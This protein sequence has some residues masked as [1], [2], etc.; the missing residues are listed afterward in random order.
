ME[1]LRILLIGSTGF[2]GANLARHLLRGQHELHVQVRAT[3]NLW[4]IHDI[5]DQVELHYFDI[6]SP[7]STENALRAANPE[8]VILCSKYGGGRADESQNRHYAVNFQGLRNILMPGQRSGVEWMINT[9]SAYEYGDSK[10][11]VSERTLPRPVGDYGL[12]KLFGTEYCSFFSR[13]LGLPVVTLRPFQAYGH[14]EDASRLFPYLLQ[15]M[16]TD[17]PAVLR[18]PNVV[19]DYVFINDLL[20]AYDLSTKK[21]RDLPL[22]SVI[23]IGTGVGHSVRE[24]AQRLRRTCRSKSKIEVDTGE[25]RTEAKIPKLVANI[26]AAASLLAWQ[27]QYPLDRGLRHYAEWF[28]SHGEILR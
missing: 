9:G 3:S 17:K 4:R 1:S 21:V 8:G 26:T 10:E 14:Y 19:R 18:N 24:V 12:S 15:C 11:V 16:T 7:R 23:N 5:R 28:A 22:G 20:R 2:V 27:P 13:R 6:T 25:A